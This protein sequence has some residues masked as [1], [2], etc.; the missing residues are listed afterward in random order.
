MDKLVFFNA[1]LLWVLPIPL[2]ALFLMAAASM[3]GV[4]ELVYKMSFK[5]VAIISLVGF[6]FSLIMNTISSSLQ[7]DMVGNVVGIIAIAFY[8]LI[9]V[10]L[11]IL[12]IKKN[13]KLAL[14]KSLAVWIVWL[15]FHFML[16][17][18]VITPIWA[19]ISFSM[20]FAV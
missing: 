17:A 15:I 10:V 1:L 13:T 8:F 16:I 18:F 9:Y 5:I 7:G 6:C 12:L 2:S 14:G 11:A 3:V 4:K 20:Q 19:I